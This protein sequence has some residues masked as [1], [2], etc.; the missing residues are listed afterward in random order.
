MH[1]NAVGVG[2]SRGARLM[3][4]MGAVQGEDTGAATGSGSVGGDAGLSQLGSIPNG[5]V[6]MAR[7]E[8]QPNTAPLRCAQCQYS[9][10]PSRT[11]GQTQCPQCGA[12]LSATHEAHQR[13]TPLCL[14]DMV[15]ALV[16]TVREHGALV[17]S[18]SQVEDVLRG[19]FYALLGDFM[20]WRIQEQRLNG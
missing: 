10:V 17:E 12:S 1:S 20:G 4:Q 13:S 6:G 9:F 16:A 3:R 8:K 14:D 19:K 18:S 15:T 11:G 5:V 7:G 2:E